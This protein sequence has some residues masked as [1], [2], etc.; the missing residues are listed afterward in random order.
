MVRRKLVQAVGAVAI[1]S[2]TTFGAHKLFFEDK[3]MERDA[4]QLSQGAEIVKN[5]RQTENSTH[6]RTQRCVDFCSLQNVDL[7]REFEGSRENNPLNSIDTISNLPY[8]R[9]GQILNVQ[10][11]RVVRI[12]YP[13]A[14]SHIAVLQF[15]LRLQQEFQGVEVEYTLTDTRRNEDQILDSL[16]GI[17]RLPYFRVINFRHE[18]HEANF[19]LEVFGKR[20]RLKY[21]FLDENEDLP[22]RMPQEVVVRS[23]VLF[24]HD[25]FDECHP[26]K[27]CNLEAFALGGAYSVVSNKTKII[28]NENSI[29]N[30][31]LV[32][33]HNFLPE[34]VNIVQG[35]FGCAQHSTG[36]AIIHI[37]D[38]ERYQRIIDSQELLHELNSNIARAARQVTN[39]TGQRRVISDSNG[40]SHFE[41]AVRLIR[42][43][44]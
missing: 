11:G 40:L 1:I 22:L 9:F 6:C 38:P 34:G 28:I 5:C 8:R 18:N 21:L 35:E 14:G 13:A 15:G 26:R 42:I 17:L 33:A 32:S 16:R 41:A 36:G 39:I 43:G 29:E 7:R 3:Q 25:S 2:L 10:S 20:T 4:A 12:A 37:A 30:Q 19:E 27:Y 31:D 23:E 44:E 24:F